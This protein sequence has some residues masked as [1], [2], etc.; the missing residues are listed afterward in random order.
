MEYRLYSFINHLYMP[1]IQWGIQ[2]AHCVSTMMANP[3]S[4]KAKKAIKTWAKESPTIII[5]QGG[6]VQTLQKLYI[7]LK[8]V[9]M[10]L[11]EQYDQYT[12]PV[13]KFHED[14]ESLG[15]IIT[16]VAVLVPDTLFNVKSTRDHDGVVH[17]TNSP[18][19]LIITPDS[20]DL[21]LHKFLS[22]IKLARLA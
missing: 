17:F 10:L 12:L 4:K 20:P 16:S 13:V 22:I 8:E 11:Q 1:P 21:L 5:C 15:G 19:E 18:Y 2:T 9:C 6:N 3:E 14:M 7:E